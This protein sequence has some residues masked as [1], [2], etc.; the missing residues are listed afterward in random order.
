[1]GSINVKPHSD[2]VEVGTNKIYG[3]VH[4]F[5]A[6]K[7]DFGTVTAKVPAHKRR[8][9]QAF[10]KPIKP[11]T[12]T[13]GAHTRRMQVPWGDIPAR[14]FLAVQPRDWDEIRS[15]LADYLARIK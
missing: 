5:G 12:I 2:R 15:A 11:R 14:P 6:K 4:Q 1:M 10:G 3:A 9:S 7:G 8:I 13:V